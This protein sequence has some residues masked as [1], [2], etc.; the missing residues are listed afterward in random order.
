MEH[1]APKVLETEI[2]ILILEFLRPQEIYSYQAVSRQFYEHYLPIAIK[3]HLTLVG[4]VNR[5]FTQ[6]PL[7]H[8][9]KG[10]E[11]AVEMGPLTVKQFA[12]IAPQWAPLSLDPRCQV[13]K[14]WVDWNGNVYGGTVDRETGMEDGLVCKLEP[15]VCIGKYQAQSGKMHGMAGKI[16]KTGH[17]QI[18][19]Y[20]HG[21]QFGDQVYYQPDNS[22]RRHVS[23]DCDGVEHVLS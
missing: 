23:I 3:A 13:F 12:M 6:R 9:E 16:W 17:Y 22:V 18:C 15:G 20:K 2:P 11:K 19:N 4:Q 21:N 5:E 10:L 7:C 8:V 14:N 1:L